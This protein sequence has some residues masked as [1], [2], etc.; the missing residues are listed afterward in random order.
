[1]ERELFEAKGPCMVAAGE[2]LEQ[3]GD[4]LEEVPITLQ[5]SSI[6]LNPT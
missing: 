4:I 2:E 1:M 5:V 3:V 6:N